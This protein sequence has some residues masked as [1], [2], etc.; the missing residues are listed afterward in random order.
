MKGETQAPRGYNER[1]QKKSLWLR[2]THRVV[3]ILVVVFVVV[4]LRIIV[5]VIRV[6]VCDFSQSPSSTRAVMVETPMNEHC[7]R[8]P[9]H[10]IPFAFEHFKLLRAK[11]FRK[12]DK[13]SAGL[14]LPSLARHALH[15]LV[16]KTRR[17]CKNDIPIIPWAV[18]QERTFHAFD[19][20]PECR[21]EHRPE[22]TS[23]EPFHNHLCGRIKRTQDL[24]AECAGYSS[25]QQATTSDH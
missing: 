9:R 6:I 2:T 13:K 21:V 22:S 14:E 15:Q 20:L 25:W 18:V 12:R 11:P 17:V 24:D 16:I 8:T 7:S 19:V 5:L 23:V 10:F 4:I 3:F 1:A